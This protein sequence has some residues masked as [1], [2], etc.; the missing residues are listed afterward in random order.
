MFDGLVD[1]QPGI[2]VNN[3]LLYGVEVLPN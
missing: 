3:R 2:I 1:L